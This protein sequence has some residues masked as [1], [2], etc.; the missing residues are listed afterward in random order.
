[1]DVSKKEEMKE[2]ELPASETYNFAD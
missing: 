1:M 2:E